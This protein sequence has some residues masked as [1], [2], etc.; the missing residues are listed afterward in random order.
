M[1]KHRLRG[2]STILGT[3]VEPDKIEELKRNKTD[4][5]NNLSRILKIIKNED[6]SSKRDRSPKR[7]R[8][9]TEL[10]GLIEDFFTH[11]QSLY[12]L[13]DRLT[14]ENGKVVSRRIDSGVSASLS[15]SSSDSDY[16]SSDEV[17]SRRQSPETEHHI[18]I[19][20]PTREG[21]DNDSETDLQTRAISARGKELEE[22]FH[23][24]KKEIESP[25]HQK[26]ELQRQIES[27][28]REAQELSARNAELQV[29]EKKT[30]E[31]QVSGLQRKFE[32][33]E[34]EDHIAELI[35]QINTLTMEATTLRDQKDEMEVR[36]T[37]GRDEALSL[38]E[39]LKN[40][41]NVMRQNSDSLS[42]KNKELEAH[43]EYLYQQLDE[44]GWLEQRMREEK[45]GLV[46]MVRDLETELESRFKEKD[47]L[48][49]E[50]RKKSYEMKQVEDENK[51]LQDRNAELKRAVT[52]A[53]E[54][55]NALAKEHESSR[56][57]ASTHAIA[58]SDQFNDLKLELNYYKE[59]KIRLE[60]QNE[61][62]QKEYSESL[63]TI[64]DQG[65]TIKEQAETI[66][67]IIAEFEE[68]KTWARKFKLNKQF[69]EKRIEELAEE[70]RGQLE[71]SIRLLYRRIRVAEQ[72]HNEN[73]DGYKLVKERYEQENKILKEKIA[74]Y[75]EKEA[76]V[77][78]ATRL[79]RIEVSN[80]LES[81]ASNL[82][83]NQVSFLRRVTKMMEEVQNARD[84]IKQRKEE[85]EQLKSHVDKLTALLKDREEQEL[86]PREKVAKSEGKVSEEGEE[87]L[88]LM[89]SVT[90]LEKKVGILEKSLKERDEQLVNLGETKREAIR[91]LCFV[92]DYHRNRCHFLKGL[93]AKKTTINRTPTPLGP[94]LSSTCADH[95]PFSLPAFLSAPR[96]VFD[97]GEYLKASVKRAEEKV[98]AYLRCFSPTEIEDKVKRILKLIGDDNHEEDGSRV[99]FSN[100]EPLVE[101]IEDF[102]NQYKSLYAQYDHL[103][104]ELR[105]KIN[106]KQG[107]ES[108]SSSSDSDSDYSSKDK[109]SK[110]G[111]LENEFQKIIDSL[112]QELEMEHKEVAELSRKVT[113]TCEEKEDL[114]LK[115]LAAL[116]KVE[117]A[118]KINADLKTDAETLDIQRSKLL[119]ENG[120]LK[121][122]LDNA[123][124]V[125]A[126]LNHRLEDLKRE[127]DNLTLEK[128]TAIRQMDEG[129][130]ITDSLRATVNQLND[131][132]LALGKELEAV[133]SEFSILKQ[134]L[135]QA[136]QQETDLSRNLKVAKEENESLKLKLS[137]LSNE[138][139]LAHDRIQELVSELTQLKE[140]LNERES[141]VSDLTQMHEGYENESS[142]KIRELEAQ[143][144]N[145]ELELESR[146]GQNRD[147][148]VQIISSRT[149]VRELVEHN[150]GLQNQISELEI[151]FKER[152][153]EL[154]AIVK[155]LEDNENRSLS[156]IADLTSQINNLLTDVDQLRA[157]KD[158]L[159]ERVLFESNEA[160]AQVK[161]ITDLVNV[162]QQEAEALQH[163]KSDLEV[164]LAKKVQ[165]NSEHLIHMQTLKEE[166]V[167]KTLDQERFVEETEKLTMQ[168]RKLESEVDMVNSQKGEVEE[169]VRVNDREIRQVR[170]EKSGLHGKISEAE[171]RLAEREFEISALQDKLK[172]AE[173]EG[174]TQI[175]ALT[176]Q[177][178]N[179]QRDLVSLHNEKQELAQQCEKLKLELDSINNS[180]NEA[181]EQ[182]RAHAHENDQLKG[183]ISGL[184][185]R[186][187]ALEKTLAEKE[188]EFSSFQDKLLGEKNEA[189]SQIIVFT[190]QIKNLQDD[191]LSLQKEKE[192]LMLHS[193]RL[194][195]EHAENLI[196]LENEK[197]ELAGKILDHQ[198][199]LEE[200]EDR[201]QKLNEEYKQVESWL[202]ECK[203][204]LEVAEKKIE[205]ITGEFHSG[206]E[207][208]DQIVTDLEQTAEDLRRDL[209]LKT[210]EIGT[211]LENIR[212]I[213]VKL[214]LSNQK[215]RVTEQ[216][217]SEKEENF[218]KA[219]EKFQQD[220]KKLEDRIAT[221]SG[222]I[223]ANSEAYQATVTNIKESMRYVMTGIDTV[224]GKLTDEHRNYE[225][226]ISN[227]SNELQLAK[228]WVREM[229][230]EKEKLKKDRH[231]LGEQLQ[232]R[233]DKELTLREMVQKLESKASKEELENKNL[234]TTVV[235]LQKSVAGLEQMVKDKDKGIMGLAE[236][237][238][239]AIRQ[240][241][242]WIDYHRSRY[243]YLKVII[244]KTPRVHRAT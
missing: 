88:S 49:E 10:V 72:L 149:E 242:L 203:V 218:R 56:N 70:I 129:Q 15:C 169:R 165:E 79:N 236:E 33:G 109:D 167:S 29:S 204:K 75:E 36:L 154:S 193:E 180:K 241:C 217:L 108:S 124:E 80:V 112:R 48:E 166:V 215:L 161:S 155:N 158:E 150:S 211:L 19:S 219:E 185:E 43:M 214:R 1:I 131:E 26:S 234:T 121:K 181:E 97:F 163:Q 194:T 117:E 123:G 118:E 172:K 24:Q 107:K 7:S 34:S 188:A 141:E 130:K 216:L 179:H 157:Q 147:M 73:K 41:L 221:L 12:A 244:S 45:E 159:E 213:E 144:T 196:L 205:E 160:S 27:K 210:D 195:G 85:M 40:Q 71:D 119:A 22:K 243:D 28:E 63:A 39:D 16:F 183:E 231:H 20:H 239:E 136:Q 206:I 106:G 21:K 11:Y 153:N 92:N 139:Q 62:M 182:I 237:K 133:T 37:L 95:L 9:E 46:G 122:Q 111:Q 199:M 127:K 110:N 102:H 177:I 145:L 173:D 68:S 198:R 197:K 230:E 125:E 200:R 162:L 93:I 103:T 189:S 138:V 67:R 171:K 190:S 66:E 186:I 14:A 53:G 44:K 152:E 31:D 174:S 57:G 170:E 2:L 17:D 47:K 235:Q 207:S 32:D 64:F 38:L 113:I 156:K 65:K 232:E 89:K 208:K 51:S 114:N 115:Y 98:K 82:E 42:D 187:A 74:I 178:D 224:M 54:E 5:E 18:T 220:Q 184:Q 23:S 201:Y 226:R 4:I 90:E 77:A 202:Q 142:N 81:A 238:R 83:K 128:E 175:M 168:I 151:K 134:Q 143:V 120:E 87:N 96:C 132:K 6:Q 146:Q 223:A 228:D 55:L 140:R 104:G 60:L 101:L 8:Q 240:L 229:N 212:N 233:N 192:E 222:I 52:H 164:Q 58:L 227:L 100:K 84:W 30:K 25:T 59:E 126:E 105:K 135:E 225:N 94:R 191:L 50:L 3:Q 61:R 13:Y 148:E 209:E 137:Q 91:Q 78:S 99:Q 35:E 116:S 76:R 176:S 86:L 69:S